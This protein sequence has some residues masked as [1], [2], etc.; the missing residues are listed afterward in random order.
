MNPHWPE[1][2]FELAR[3]ALARQAAESRGGNFHRP[4]R[5][6]DGGAAQLGDTSLTFILLS[7]YRDA[8]AQTLPD[9]AALVARARAGI[10][11]INASRLAR[12]SRNFGVGAK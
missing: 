11:A 5:N 7:D 10:S 2:L 9:D 4:V 3:S 8:A 12:S 6:R 1:L